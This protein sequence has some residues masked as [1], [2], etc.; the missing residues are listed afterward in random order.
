MNPETFQLGVV[1]AGVFFLFQKFYAL[2][3]WIYKRQLWAN[4]NRRLGDK[5]A[6]I[7]YPMG[8]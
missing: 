7:F 4:A 1:I 6:N 8:K 3:A 5:T 2:G